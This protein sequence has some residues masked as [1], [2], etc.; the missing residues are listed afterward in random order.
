MDPSRQSKSQSLMEGFVFCS[1]KSENSEKDNDV[2]PE[3][4]SFGLYKNLG[5]LERDYDMVKCDAVSAVVVSGSKMLG[6]EE[7]FEAWCESHMGSPKGCQFNRD[8]EMIQRTAELENRDAA[9]L[10]SLFNSK[11][12]EMIWT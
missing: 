11:M 1:E 8:E 5:T 12:V 9:M 10:G 3:L 4:V 6:L 7:R 2:V